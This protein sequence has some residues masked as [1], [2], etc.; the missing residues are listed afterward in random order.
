MNDEILQGI[1]DTQETQRLTIKE[2]MEIC[3]TLITRVLAL[4]EEIKKK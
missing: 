1:I 4:E 3:E 2:L